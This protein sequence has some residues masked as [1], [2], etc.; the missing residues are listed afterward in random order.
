VYKAILEAAI[1]GGSWAN[2]QSRL[3]LRT[4]ALAGRPS[5]RWAWLRVAQ[6]LYRMLR[7][8][9]ARKFDDGR[10]DRRMHVVT[11]PRRKP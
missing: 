11:T 1:R 5:E 6:I 4:E 2:T 7:I 3:E 8:L 10:D 9:T